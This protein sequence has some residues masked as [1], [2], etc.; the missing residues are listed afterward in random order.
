MADDQGTISCPKCGE[1]IDVNEV[2][3][4][5]V[6]TE[7][8][9]K[10]DEERAQD[11]KA[12]E[13]RE[14]ELQA[15]EDEFERLEEL[16]QKEVLAE[17]EKQ[18]KIKTEVAREEIKKATE[19][20]QKDA[21]KSMQMEL[22]E[23]SDK[24]KEYGKVSV[25]NERLKREKNEL[26]EQ[27]K[28]KAEKDLNDRL[29]IEKEKIAEQERNR[30][31]F[32]EKELQKKLD[33][34]GKLIEEMK[35]KQEQGSMQTQGE[36]QELAIE[37]WLQSTFPL[38]EISEIK[39][40]QRGADCLQ[41]VNT[42]QRQNCGTIYYESKRTANW[43]NAWIEKFKTDIRTQNADVGVLVT[44]AMPPDFER[45]GFIDGILVCTFLEF[46]IL[47]GV[48]RKSIVDISAVS[49]VQTNKGD[50]KDLL[51][52]FVTGNEFRR[53]I[54]AVVESFYQL[55]D[56]LDS[57]KRAFQKQWHQREK[58]IEKGQDSFIAMFGSVQGIAGSAVGDIPSL[59]FGD[60]E[61]HDLNE[62][63]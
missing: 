26:E 7:L 41:V 55:K 32:K 3:Y 33:D 13:T 48:L 15:R 21:M 27:Y 60:S 9:K 8:K 23:K 46:K 6:D 12:I 56:Q 2:I 4:R 19:E 35:R 44:Q 62:D 34:Q 52:D 22:N 20:E 30:S 39:K 59:G 40:G 42:Q 17:V 16:R 1:L 63:Q 49:A 43:Q 47:A 57:E 11:K 25:E 28:I 53:S 18:V 37:D 45:A 58:L 50:K 31:Q 29:L 36:V 38:D 61:D 10:Y 5:R 14:S 51:Y 24:L 54:E